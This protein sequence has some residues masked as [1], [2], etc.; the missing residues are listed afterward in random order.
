[1]GDGVPGTADAVKC[2]MQY[3][4]QAME[5]VNQPQLMMCWLWCAWRLVLALS[6]A[7]G[8]PCKEGMAVPP[9][10]THAGVQRGMPGTAAESSEM[11]DRAMQ[12][13]RE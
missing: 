3:K 13:T 7:C 4:K 2:A 9:F 1:V 6:T 8:K 11:F 12:S 10:S 5:V